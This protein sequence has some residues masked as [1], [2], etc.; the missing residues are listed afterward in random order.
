MTEDKLILQLNNITIPQEIYQSMID[1][2]I[3]TKEFSRSSIYIN[4]KRLELSENSQ[5]QDLLKSLFEGIKTQL[6]IY[7]NEKK[8]FEFDL[9]DSDGIKWFSF[10]YSSGEQLYSL[11]LNPELS[12]AKIEKIRLEKELSLKVKTKTA[13]IKI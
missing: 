11:L 12:Y 4:R 1:V 2:I 9:L 3:D 7:P 6:H 10:G 5:Y 13:N 8:R